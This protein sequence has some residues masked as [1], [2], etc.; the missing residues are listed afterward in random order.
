[1]QVSKVDVKFRDIIH[2]YRSQPQS[3]LHVVRNVFIDQPPLCLTGV[4]TSSY[5]LVIVLS[6]ESVLACGWEVVEF[7]FLNQNL[8]S[9]NCS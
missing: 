6:V 7:K 3:K 9:Q 8:Q 4:C 2:H 1:M 5:R